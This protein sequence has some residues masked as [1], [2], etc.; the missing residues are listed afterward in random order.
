MKGTLQLRIGGIGRQPMHLEYDL[1]VRT[2]PDGMLL[3]DPE[4]KETAEV[5]DCELENVTRVGDGPTPLTA[6]MISFLIDEKFGY[7]N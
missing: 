5:W 4:T 3:R 7:V 2:I 6:V 1:L